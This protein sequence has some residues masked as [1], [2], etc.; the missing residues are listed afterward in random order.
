MPTPTET[1]GSLWRALPVGT[2]AGKRYAGARLDTAA[3]K[4][5]ALPPAE[6]VP[7]R[8]TRC[9]AVRWFARAVPEE[10]LA[11]RATTMLG[12]PVGP[13]ARRPVGPSAGGVGGP[14]ESAAGVAD[15]GAARWVTVRWRAR[16]WR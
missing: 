2:V 16:G 12:R 9:G 1:D 13:S 11:G 7:G 10:Q 5:I 4:R 8:R 15:G 6:G 14:A 3:R